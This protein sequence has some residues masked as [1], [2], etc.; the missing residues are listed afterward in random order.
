MK[1]LAVAW[2]NPTS[3]DMP[4]F[5]MNQWKAMGHEVE[6]F[7]N[8]LDVLDEPK[9]RFLDSI[10]PC[11]HEIGE[12]R[13]AKACGKTRPDI[14]LFFYHFIS[15]RSMQRI[16]RDCGCK[17]GIY[18]DN[19]H[20]FWRDTAP[21]MSA[22]DFVVVHD[23]YVI[24]LIQGTLSGRNPNVYHLRGA[25]EPTEHRH[26]ELTAWDRERYG[27]E[28][29]FIGGSGPDRLA[30]LSLITAYKLRIWGGCADAWRSVPSLIP[31]IS[32]EPVYGLKK[33]KIYNAASIVLNIEESEKQIDA[34]NPRIP[35]ALACGGFVLTNY[36][37]DLEKVGFR[38]GESIA[39]FKSTDEMVDKAS[40]YLANPAERTRISQNGR[41]L[42]IE[43]LTYQKLSREWMAWMESVVHFL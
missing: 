5:H 3:T 7:P 25:A 40:H 24:P 39:W 27:C 10:E 30:A 12:D 23:R 36:T 11:R 29:A 4:L 31:C 8:D 32:D 13:V 26:V 9:C 6:A 38:D 2:M 28:I 43:S 20:L 16:R 21:F 42:V 34:I 19:N 1:V 35:E 22:A 14:L 15:V 33:T 18:L 41:K 17:V 37:S